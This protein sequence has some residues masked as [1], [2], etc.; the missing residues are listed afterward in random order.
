MTLIIKS[1]QCQSVREALQQEW[2]DT[3]G[4]GGYSSS[5]ILNCHTRKYHGL[6]VLNLLHPEG[7]F[8]LLSKVEDSLLAGDKEFFLSS[9]KY[10]G[11]FFPASGQYLYEFRQDLYPHFIY[12][13]GDIT[14]HKR[15]LL[16]RDT[17]T[18]LIRYDL[19]GADFPVT[20]RIK[21]LLAYRGFHELAHENSFLRPELDFKSVRNGFRI[22][23]Y[24][25]MPALF[26]QS[27]R[28]IETQ[29]LPLWYR[30]FEYEAE[31]ARGFACQEDL[32]HPARFETP[33]EPGET[34]ILAAG[35]EPLKTPLLKCWDREE[36][37]RRESTAT[38]RRRPLKRLRKPLALATARELLI[39]SSRHF[40]V[41]LPP[42]R[43][44]VIAGYHW[45]GDWGRDTLI[46]LPGLTFYAGRPELGLEILKGFIPVERNGLL[47]NYFGPEG[48]NNAYN[49]VDAALWF[50]WAVQQMIVRCGYREEVKHCLWPTMKSILEHY[51]N[52]TD[53]DIYMNSD[54]LLH[55][56][57]ALTQLTWMDACVLGQPVT[58]RH[59]YAVEINALWYNAL[60]LA[61]RLAQD[62]GEPN[63]P[64]ASVADRL[65]QAFLPTFWLEHEQGL[66]DVCNE[67]GL[68]A[69]IRPNQIF[70][71][72]LPYSPLPPEKARA[73]VERVRSDL[74]TPFGLRT[75]SPSSPHYRGRYEGDGEA[76]DGAYHQGT[77][78]PWLLGPYGEAYLKVNRYSP[79]ARTLLRGHLQ[80]LLSDHLFEQGLG[81]IAEIFD[82]DPPHRPAGCIAQAWSSAE[83][84]RL[85][86]L[87][88]SPPK[89]KPERPS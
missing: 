10:P 72:S 3:N 83:L 66:G 15:I 40:L 77:V 18:V 35:L 27:S 26:L 8:V 59:G 50:F 6:L 34:V 53:F 25:N 63:T 20:L 84:I 24:Q 22:A 39:E 42:H 33:L 60:C 47:P 69:S 7:R 9:H 82:G 88:E 68:D 16:V 73:V 57:N 86:C 67:Q 52:G 55:A 28:S 2:L 76:R 17:Q 54:G 71:V 80:S 75:L 74:L 19:S 29:P 45:F 41:T 48:R 1:E 12:R 78:W 36:A 4:M 44:S 46:A 81:H 79:E 11:T 37:A 65:R 14:L 58:P 70:A 30:N 32:F 43:P 61:D 62:F 13:M 51:M 64:Y 85:L 31:A 5:T 38:T 87:L 56:G 21:P 89:N 49:S 23:P